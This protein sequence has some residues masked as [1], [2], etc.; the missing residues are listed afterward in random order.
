[1]ELSLIMIFLIHIGLLV[2]AKWAEKNIGVY[3][4]RFC[5]DTRASL[6]L[7]AYRS[8]VEEKRKRLNRPDSRF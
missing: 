6:G 7:F 3:D 1:M 4:T 8:K 5:R 2:F